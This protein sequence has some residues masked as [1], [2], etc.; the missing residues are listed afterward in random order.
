MLL[1]F[2]KNELVIGKPAIIDDQSSVECG[3]AVD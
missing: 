1:I 2:S 3:Q